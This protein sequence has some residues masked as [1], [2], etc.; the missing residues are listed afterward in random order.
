MQNNRAL[1]DRDSIDR[2]EVLQALIQHHQLISVFL[3][4]S[5]TAHPEPTLESQMEM[6][7]RSYWT[8]RLFSSFKGMFWRIECWAQRDSPRTKGTRSEGSSHTIVVS[9]S[10]VVSFWEPAKQTQSSLR[11]LCNLCEV[12]QEGLQS[13]ALDEEAIPWSHYLGCFSSRLKLYPGTRLTPFQSSHFLLSRFLGAP[14]SR[15]RFVWVWE[16]FWLS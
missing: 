16:C 3:L 14:Y 5:D 15:H 11:S 2:V 13:H 9:D 8:S 7:P 6:H 1:I 4:P 12:V 10:C